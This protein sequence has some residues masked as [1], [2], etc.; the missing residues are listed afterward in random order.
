MARSRIPG[1]MSRD[2]ESATGDDFVDTRNV[3]LQ[4]VGRSQ[5]PV[6]YAS[7]Q[8]NVQILWRCRQVYL[9]REQSQLVRDSVLNRQPV[10]CVQQ[11]V[12][13]SPSWHLEHDPGQIVLYPLQF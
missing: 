9:V 7:F 12:G 2:T 8:Q 11:R 4:H 6:T 13:V 5:R 1:F 3:K 10:K